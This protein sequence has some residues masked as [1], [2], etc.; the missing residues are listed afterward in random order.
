MKQFSY[1]KLR[2][3]GDKPT[4]K[5]LEWTQTVLNYPNLPSYRFTRVSDVFVT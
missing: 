2:G 3:H 4:I 1:S 5:P